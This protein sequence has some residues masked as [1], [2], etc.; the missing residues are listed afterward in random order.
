MSGVIGSDNV[1]A[2]SDGA[3]SGE[4]SDVDY[5]SNLAV[6]LANHCPVS[7]ERPAK[8]RK[9]SDVVG[10]GRCVIEQPV[11]AAQQLSAKTQCNFQSRPGR[12]MRSRICSVE[13]RISRLQGHHLFWL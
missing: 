11:A 9:V 13:L 6:G 5:S 1:R 3:E 7:V 10:G 8:A 2:E 4:V 12:G